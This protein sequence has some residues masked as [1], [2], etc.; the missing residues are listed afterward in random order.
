MDEFAPSRLVTQDDGSFSLC[1]D[2]FNAGSGIMDERGLQGGGYTWHAIVEALVRL[3][4]PDIKAA[5]SYDPEGS[6]FVPYGM[7]RAALL[8]AREN[9]D[10]DLLE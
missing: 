10:G 8:E 6:M 2:D 7:D 9:T 3:H 4:T 1:F 5:V